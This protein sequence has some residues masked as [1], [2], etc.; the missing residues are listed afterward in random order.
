M[1]DTT[2]AIVVKVIEDGEKTTH[3]FKEW[4]SNEHGALYFDEENA[5]YIFRGDKEKFLS[6]LKE[7]TAKGGISA[8]LVLAVLVQIIRESDQVLL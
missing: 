2:K 6:Q 8:M 5:L 4:Y 1:E 3:V 7:E